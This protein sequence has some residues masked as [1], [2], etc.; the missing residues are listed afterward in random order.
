MENLQAE[1]LR[2]SRPGWMRG[3]GAGEREEGGGAGLSQAGDPTPLP[4]ASPPCPS[5]PTPGIASSG[6]TCSGQ[7]SPE[8]GFQ[9]LFLLLKPL[10]ITSTQLPGHTPSTPSTP[11]APGPLLR[12]VR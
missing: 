9:L 1:G 7:G 10:G 3:V 11:S 8:G 4:P 12:T 6:P 2:K 5:T